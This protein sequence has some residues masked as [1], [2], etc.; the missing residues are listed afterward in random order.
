LFGDFEEIRKRLLGVVP[1]ERL[2]AA[3]ELTTD[4]QRGASRQQQNQGKSGRSKF[5]IQ[6]SRHQEG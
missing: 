6:P 4:S 1:Q 3:L 5:H 2:P